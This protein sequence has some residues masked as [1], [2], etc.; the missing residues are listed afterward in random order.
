MK[1][2]VVIPLVVIGFLT[3]VYLLLNL[4]LNDNSSQDDHVK[5]EVYK[6]EDGYAYKILID[7]KMFIQ[8]EYVPSVKGSH[9]F[10]TEDDA[11]KTANLVKNRILLN[12]RPSITGDDLQKLG[13]SV[14][15]LVDKK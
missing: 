10:C 4:Y 9:H 7:D 11:K 12:R 13:V 1:K 8:Q 5:V 2:F 3:G 6:I 14:T 15:C